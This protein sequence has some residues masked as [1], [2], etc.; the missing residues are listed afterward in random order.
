M[1]KLIAGLMSIV[2]ASSVYAAPVSLGNIPKASSVSGGRQTMVDSVVY[3]SS[4][5]IGIGSTAPRGKL[6]VRSA[7]GVDGFIYGNG[8]QMTGVVTTSSQYANYKNTVTAADGNGAF[9]TI[10]IVPFSVNTYTNINRV[11]GTVVNKTENGKLVEIA[12]Y[13]SSLAQVSTTGK[14]EIPENGS[15]SFSLNNPLTVPGTYYLAFGTNSTTSTF[16][17]NSTAAGYYMTAATPLPSTLSSMT[18][19]TGSMPALTLKGDAPGIAPGF[20]YGSTP[21]GIYVFG[22][23]PVSSQPYGR[24]A[25]TSKICY[26]ID[27][28]ATFVDLMTEPTYDSGDYMIDLLVLSSK[29]YILT[30]KLKLYRSTG[31]TASDTW[32][33]ISCPTTAGLRHSNAQAL[34]YGFTGIFQNYIFIGEYSVIGSEFAPDG[35]RILRYDT[36]G[37]SWALSQEFTGARHIHAFYNAGTAIYASIGDAGYTGIGLW[38]LTPAGIGAGVGGS[39]TWTAWTTTTSP[40]S[41]NYAVNIIAGDGTFISGIIGAADVVGNH[42][43]FSKTSGTAGSFEFS[44]LIYRPVG[45]GSETVWSVIEDNTYGNI[46]YFTAESSAP[47]LYVT[48]PP[49][50]QTVKLK[51]LTDTP[52]AFIG[53]TV[54]AGQV[55]MTYNQR[56]TIPSATISAGSRENEPSFDDAIAKNATTSRSVSI[57][58]TAQPGVTL[59]IGGFSSTKTARSN[60]IGVKGDI[61]VDQNIYVDGSLYGNLSG[62]IGINSTSPRATL[63]VNGSLYVNNTFNVIGTAGNIGTDVNGNNLTFSLADAN[64]LNAISANG[65]LNIITNGR[66]PSYLT[67][68]ASFRSNGDVYFPNGNVSIGSTVPQ[69]KLEVDGGIYQVSGNVLLGQVS[70]NVGVGT[71]TPTAALDIGGVSLTNTLRSNTLGVKG[72][73]EVD[74][75]IYTDGRLLTASGSNTAPAYAFSAEPG[76]GMYRV[77]TNWMGFAINSAAVLQLKAAGASAAGY[78]IANHSNPL[79]YGMRFGSDGIIGWTDNINASS[80]T[81]DIGVSRGAVGKLYVGNGTAGTYAGTLIA[82]NIG[83]GTTSPRYTLEADGSVYIGGIGGNTIID[84]DGSIYNYGNATVFEDLRFPAQAL[85]AGATAAD[86]CAVI[87]STLR[88]RCFDGATT[89][90][91]MEV[92]VQFPHRRRLNSIIYPHV[93]WG[94]SNTDAGNVKWQLEYSCANINDTFPA[95]STISVIDASDTVAHKHQIVAFPEIDTSLYGTL[96]SM[97][98]MRIFRNPADGS[99]NYE[100]DAELYEFD[101]HYEVDTDGSRSEYVK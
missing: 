46:Y 11:D 18:A 59:D 70:G 17:T 8:S 92:S 52:P 1:R 80:D 49:Y 37:D 51:D 58:T 89:A 36:V 48:F 99:D 81:M 13:D 32:D 74:Q 12:I 76:M 57:G 98:L 23:D 5:N 55:I 86:P 67:A 6:D 68:S 53:R 90:E 15:F 27:T 26:S 44:P 61:E 94:P 91:S 100:S 3:E 9:S 41:S 42:L 65:Y 85:A 45:N 95:S 24:N 33:D 83:L 38:Q 101:I 40:H 88:T 97:C 2:L 63:D 62:N 60:S 50:V 30:H 84:T 78:A 28:G 54:K 93:H 31:L 96:S 66:T 73:V 47:A 77:T 34:P 10:R 29:I 82:G 21:S 7:T 25:N 22:W 56:F 20:S 19:A 39:D 4:S 71:S 43:L 35:P 69:A 75:N 72:D 79:L 64:Y 87:G 14:R 16:N